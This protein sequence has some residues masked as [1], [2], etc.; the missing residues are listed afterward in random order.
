[1]FFNRDSDRWQRCSDARRKGI[2]AF[3]RMFAKKAV[4]TTIAM[5]PWAATML[6][7]V[8]GLLCTLAFALVGALLRPDVVDDLYAW[9]LNPTLEPILRRLRET[10]SSSS[11]FAPA[12]MDLSMPPLR[13]SSPDQSGSV[14]WCD[15]APVPECAKSR[16]GSTI[17]AP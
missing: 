10:G 7:G 13:R 2:D 17:S 14:P 1:M 6:N 3:E 15:L 5:T 11:D 16:A 4:V 8:L 12:P 9:A